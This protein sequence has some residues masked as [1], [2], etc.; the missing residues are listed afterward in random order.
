MGYWPR[1]PMYS[2]AGVKFS[3]D[4]SIPWSYNY[5]LYSL[6]Y[7]YYTKTTS[8]PQQRLFSIPFSICWD[9]YMWY[10]SYIGHISVSWRSVHNDTPVRIIQLRNKYKFFYFHALFEK[11]LMLGGILNSVC[12]DFLPCFTVDWVIC[13][14]DLYYQCSLITRLSSYICHNHEH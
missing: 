10:C 12:R 2:M 9:I 4:S 7:N 6:Y 1:F 14:L 5:Y 8:S 3:Y 13:H 11:K